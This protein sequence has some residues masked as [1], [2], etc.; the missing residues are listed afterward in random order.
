M[1]VLITGNMGYVGP[2]VTQ[3]LRRNYPNACLV[4]LD[5][6]W[7]AHCLTASAILPETCIDEQRFRDTRWLSER[8]LEGF[9]AVIHLAAVSNDPIGNRFERVTNEINFVA[10][11]RLAR[12]AASAGVRRFVFASSC[13]IYG[14]AGDGQARTEADPV[15]PLTPY[16][17]SKIATEEALAAT[18]LGMEI[19]CLRFATA[20]GISPR[21]RLDLVLNDFVAGALIQG[22]IT[23]LSD[24]SPWRPL[25][26]VRDM[27]RAIEWAIT[28]DSLSGKFIKVNVGANRWNF[29]VREL[30]EAA[31]RAIPGTRVS[32]LDT[33]PA[34]KRSY[35]VDFG[36]FERLAPDFQP[37]ETLDSTINGLLKGLQTI[38]LADK[39]YRQSDLIRL[40]VLDRLIESGDLNE[41]LKWAL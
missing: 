31:A 18:D 29:Q 28:R 20:C 23:V 1:R 14:S 13:S 16:A 9:E 5:A 6:G 32:I 24:G 17:R 4:G 19:T 30:A 2:V 40:K 25:I 15:F 10:S 26:D 12:M 37:Q 3:L 8:D 34:D 41:E 35:K 22:E 36:L 21:L 33:A 7:F 38:G 27:A 11:V 39:N